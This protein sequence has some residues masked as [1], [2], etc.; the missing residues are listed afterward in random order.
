MGE[1][2]GA[3]G[4][5]RKAQPLDLH[6]SP[7]LRWN[8]S[9]CGG[10]FGGRYKRRIWARRGCLRLQLLGTRHSRRGR[11]HPY[12]RRG[13]LGTLCTLASSAELTQLTEPSHPQFLQ[14]RFHPN[15]AFWLA[16]I[17]SYRASR[18]SLPS[19]SPRRAPLDPRT[20]L[21]KPTTQKWNPKI[22]NLKK[23]NFTTKLYYFARVS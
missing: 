12:P 18:N 5:H 14:L 20:P 3:P 16:L 9:L 21:I 15:S 6:Q 22:N 17:L 2:S 7:L 13:S 1:R 4:V 11:G 8:R 19:P 10:S 23:I